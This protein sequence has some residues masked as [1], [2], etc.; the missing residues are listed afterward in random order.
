M[1]LDVR[2]DGCLFFGTGMT[3]GNAELVDADF[4]SVSGDKSL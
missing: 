3:A 4:L 2:V 1:V